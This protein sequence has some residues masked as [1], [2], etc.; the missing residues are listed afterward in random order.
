MSLAALALALLAQGDPRIEKVERLAVDIPRPLS[1]APLA[2]TV[3]SEKGWSGDLRIRSRFGFSVLRRIDVPARGFVREILPSLDPDRIEAGEA[4][5]RVPALEGRA[6]LAVAVDARLPYA[7]ALESGPRARFVKVA[8]ADLAR[9]LAD[10]LLE[11]VDLLLLQDVAGLDVGLAPAWVV[12]P[13]RGAAEGALQA[14]SRAPSIGAVD[15]PVWTLAPSGGWV[16]AKRS[17]AVFFAGAYA[18]GAFALLA[19]AARRGRKAFAMG[20]ATAGLAGACAY[21]AFFPRSQAWIEEVSVLVAPAS[22]P[23]REHRIWFAGAATP[24]SP[25]LVFP[26]TVKP[27]FPDSSGADR[28]F[29]IRL[30]D[31]GCEVDGLQLG[32]RQPACF[33]ALGPGEAGGPG[34]LHGAGFRRADRFS[35]L[36][37][38][39]A[40]ARIPD[41]PAVPLPPDPR[42]AV[43]ERFFEGPVLFGWREGATPKDIDA[44]GL[45]DVRV[46]ARFYVGRI[47]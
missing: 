17:R 46:R 6:E 22:G 21:A 31:A 28:P 5:A 26:R 23:S 33:A 37:D 43:F 25:K 14:A 32:P 3:A 39:A 29:E 16:P 18:F 45:A 36:G 8:R 12:A 24:S 15:A 41:G 4:F 11:G 1:W 47:R 44:S 13:D 35:Y 10:G 20:V 38:L 2:V 27:I 34:A 19:L 42:R 7:D 30:L 9:L 40:G